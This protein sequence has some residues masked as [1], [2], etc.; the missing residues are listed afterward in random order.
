MMNDQDGVADGLGKELDR[1]CFAPGRALG[2]LTLMYGELM[3]LAQLEASRLAS[4][5][6]IARAG[7]ALPETDDASVQAWWQRQ[8]VGE[9]SHWQ[10]SLDT[11]ADALRIHQLYGRQ[12]AKLLATT[13]RQLSESGRDQA[14]A[15]VMAPGTVPVPAQVTGVLTG[16]A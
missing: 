9:Q 7:R 5:D 3:W 16:T 11:L 12:L 15:P 14:T 2:G 4:R 13:A 10:R 8:L 1:L 6:A